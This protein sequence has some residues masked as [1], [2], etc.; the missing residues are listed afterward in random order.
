[1]TDAANAANAPIAAPG[2]D[3]NLLPYTSRPFPHSAPPRLAGQAAMF[4]LSAPAVSEARVLELG[5]ASGGNIIPLALRFPGARFRGIDLTERHVRDGQARVAALELRNVAIEQGDIGALD[6]KGQRFDYIVCHGVYSWV[7]EP[8]REAILRICGESLADTGVAYISYNVYP[9]WQVRGTIR[10]M[11]ISCAGPQ[12]E[13]ATR[14]AKARAMLEGIAKAPRIANP[15]G[16]MLRNE[17]RKLTARDDDYLLGEFLDAENAPCHFSDFAAKAASCGLNYL[18]E[19]ELGHC[20]PEH[21]GP[22]VGG[23]IRGLSANDLVQLEQHMD[24]FK[25]RTFR[26]T[27]LVKS[28]QS[29]IQRMLAPERLRG[30]HVS[31]RMTCTA[32]PDGSWQFSGPSGVLNTTDATM[33]RALQQL[34]EVYPATRTVRELA[35][36]VRAADREGAIRDAVFQAVLVGLADVASVPLR[37][38][39]AGR[40]KGKPKAGRLARLD[41]AR[42][43]GWTTGPGHDVVPLDAVSMVLLPLMDGTRDCEALKGGLLAAVGAGLIKLQDLASGV[44]ET[45]AALDAAAAAHVSRTIE[46]LAGAR[47]L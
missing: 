32:R 7:P 43:T 12:G 42:R 1:M 21:M 3:Y 38:D 11:M 45:G 17:A 29:R 44:E 16:E 22:E 33:S 10:D 23:L 27:L 34:T 28:P 18:C 15:Y 20:F 40:H 6:L 24:I 2:G 31:A 13:P 46:N 30:L 26:Q 5:C 39:P 19:A 36:E 25:G 4:G 8:V 47:L 9:G 35:A 41:A 37:L 14:V